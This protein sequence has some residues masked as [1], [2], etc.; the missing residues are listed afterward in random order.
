MYFEAART[1]THVELGLT[2]E[3]QALQVGA[4]QAA[5][6][7]V[8]LTGVQDLRIGTTRLAAL[9]LTG[10][11]ELREFVRRARAAGVRVG[12][13]GTPPD[14]L[15]LVDETLASAAPAAPAVPPVPAIE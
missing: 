7:Q 6:A 14:Q 12:F 9:D 15:R 4:L 13:D 2:G 10:A 5:L 8:D 3:W 11:F 1:G